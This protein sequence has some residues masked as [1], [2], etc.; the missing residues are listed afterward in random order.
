MEHLRSLIAALGFSRVETFIASGNVIFET[1]IEHESTL[2]PQIEHHLHQALGYAVATFIRAAPE[3]AAIVQYQPFAPAELDTAD[4]SL[5]V[6]FLPALPSD[7]AQHKLMAF[8]NTIDDFHFHNREIYWLCRK[9]FSESTFS[10][11]RLEKTIGMSATIRN[12]TTVQKLAAKYCA[13]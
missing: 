9:K 3:L 12:I 4:N 2:E 1:S 5:Y 8:R 10:G 7:E 13:S 6:A 11:A